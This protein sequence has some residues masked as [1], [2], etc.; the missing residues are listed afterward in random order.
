MDDYRKI[1]I[2]LTAAGMLFFFL[3]IMLL[4]DKGL[5]AMGNVRRAAAPATTAAAAAAAALPPP[6]LPPPLQPRRAA[7]EL[8]RRI[9]HARLTPRVR[10][11]HAD[12]LPLGRRADHRREEDVQ[13]LLPSAQVEGCAAATPPRCAPPPRRRRQRARCRARRR[14]PLAQARLAS[15]AGS[16]SSSSAG[17]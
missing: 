6:P 12:P 5:L 11:P 16:R 3:G 15:S 14:A 10:V 13:V 2:G 7:A 1:G 17:R 8:R 4:F 9:A